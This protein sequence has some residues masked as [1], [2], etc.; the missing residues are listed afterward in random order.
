MTPVNFDKFK[1]QIY[2][3]DYAYKFLLLIVWRYLLLKTLL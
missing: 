3:P 1:N 2:F